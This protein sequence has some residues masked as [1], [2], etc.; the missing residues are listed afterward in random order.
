MPWCYVDSKR[1]IF[2]K[3]CSVSACAGLSWHT[4][5]LPPSFAPTTAP[6]WL[7]NSPTLSPTL[8]PTAAATDPPTPFPTNFPTVLTTQTL[9]TPVPTHI[10][11]P[12]P[13]PAPTPLVT[14]PMQCWCTGMKDKDGIGSK[15]STWDSGDRAWCYVPM[16]CSGAKKSHFKGAMGMYWK[17]CDSTTVQLTLAQ[18][19]QYEMKYGAFLRRKYTPHQK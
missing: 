2:A 11:V 5:V 14:L 16:T 8:V 6:T 3:R 12:T 13:P 9:P 19:A 4:C 7:S 1:C 10:L 17:H 15:C 18:S